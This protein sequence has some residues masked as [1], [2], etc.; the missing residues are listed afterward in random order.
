MQKLSLIISRKKG[1]RIS[2]K[3]AKDLENIVISAEGGSIHVVNRIVRLFI[4]E[5]NPTPGRI[6]QAYA[7]LYQPSEAITVDKNMAGLGRI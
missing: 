4:K 2:K 7:R 5:Q 6:S 3:H 1:S